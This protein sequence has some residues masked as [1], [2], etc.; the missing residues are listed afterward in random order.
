LVGQQFGSYQI[1][2]ADDFAYTDPVD[3]SISKNQGLRIGFTDGSRIIFRLSGTGTSGATL[4]IYFDSY[5]ADSNKQQIDSQ[6]ALKELMDIAAT[7]SNLEKLTGRTE[8]S[9][10][11]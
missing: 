3:K 6:K 8:P 11:T 2:Y 1:E 7:I 10:I 4:R 9:V 5:E